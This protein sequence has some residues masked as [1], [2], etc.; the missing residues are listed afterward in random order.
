MAFDE[1]SG[2]RFRG[3][4]SALERVTDGWHLRVVQPYRALKTY[5]CPGC[6]QEIFPR[7]MHLV[8]WPDGNP[9]QR[10]HWHRACWERHFAELGRARQRGRRRR[11]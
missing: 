9:E 7:T 3:D 8:V 4:P 5:R 2:W 6:D 11:A 1:G 10:R